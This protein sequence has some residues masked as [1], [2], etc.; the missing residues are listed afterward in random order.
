MGTSG[1]DGAPCG[2]SL[3]GR[4]AETAADER[5]RIVL[6]VVL[7]ET[8]ALLGRPPSAIDPQRPYLDYGYNSLAAVALTEELSSICGLALPLTM[9]FDQPNPDAVARYLLSRMGL[10]AAESATG[11]E[12]PPPPSGSGADGADDIIAVVGVACR[13]PGGVGSPAEL[14]RLVDEGR[15][16]I[17]G[18]P[19]DRGWPLEE[20][21]HPDPDHPGTAYTRSGGFV[22]A[23]TEFD[24]EFFGIS[25]REALAMDPQ[26][27]LL[28]E[29]VWEAFEDA[30]IDPGTL[31]AS[32]TGVFAGVSG[33][34]YSYV[35]R[36]GGTGLQGYWGI[37]TL[38]A[39]ASGRIAY[40]FGFEGPALTVDTACSSSLVATHLAMRSLRHGECS[41]AVV[42]GVT[43]A[44]T[45][46]VYLEFSRQRA[47]S[48]D[49]R[50]R[51]FAETA[52]GTGFS[53]GLG[54]LLLERLSDARRNGHRVHAVL[55]G[56]AM[57]QDGASNG[58]TAPNGPSQE[59]VIRAA[60]ADAGL[61]PDEVD[62]VEA[63]GTAT[64][65]GDPIEAQALLATYG[66]DRTPD[67]PLWLG[68]LKSNIGHTQAAA[69]VGGLIKMIMAMGAE[70]LPATLHADEPTAKVDWSSG[71]VALLTAARP[72]PRAERPRRAGVS[73]FGASGTNAHIIVEEA[74]AEQPAEPGPPSAG[75][76]SAGPR[77]PAA[78]P[79]VW[80]LSGKQQSGLSAQAR[81]LRAWLLAD[82]GL[83][84]VDVGYSLATTRAPLSHR[85]VVV[86]H[87][88]DDLLAG[89][90]RIENRGP[91][92]E[93]AGVSARPGR[94]AFVF[95][96]QGS[97]WAGMAV[98]LLASS[99]VFAERMRE[100][101]EAL[102]PYT[103]W[104][105]LDVLNGAPDAPSLDRVDVVQP[106]L[107]A[108]MV[109][110]AALWRSYGVEPDAVVGHSQ[111]EIAAAC[112]AGALTLDDAARVVS[113]RSKEIATLGRS[114]GMLSIAE[115][116]EDVRARLAMVSGEVSVAAVNGPS[117]VIVSGDSASLDELFEDCVA[118]DVWVRR[119]PVDYASHSPQIEDLRERLHTALAPVTP[120]AGQVAF[121]STVVGK[122]VETTTLDG[123]YWYANLRN[124]V[125]FEQTVRDLADQGHR[126]FVE[127]SPHPV[128]T[129]ALQQSME[130]LGDPDAVVL[131]S[132]KR[133]HGRLEDFLGSLGEAYARGV[134]VDWPAAFAGRPAH[135][136]DLP[137]YAFTRQR[138]WATTGEGAGDPRP[139]GLASAHHPLLAGQVRLAGGLGS[140]FTGRLSLEQL[141]WLTDHTVFGEVFVPGTA[142][143]DLAASAGD[144]LGVPVVEELTLESPLVVR[145]EGIGIQLQVAEPDA[146]GRAAFTLHSEDGADGWTQNASGV[147]AASADTPHT[148]EPSADAPSVEGPSAVWPP[149]GAVAIPIGD[150][151]DRL[152]DRGMEYGGMFRGLRAAW[153]CGDG[154]CAEV[155]LDGGGEDIDPRHLLH[156]ALLDAAFH[157][158]FA[159]RSDEGGSGSARLP[160]A[161]SGV[162][163]RSG[164]HTARELRVRLTPLGADTLR[165]SARDTDGHL[166]VSVDSVLARPVSMAQLAAAR[167]VTADCL[168]GVDWVPATADA[169][170]SPD[171]VAVL[172][173]GEGLETP[174]AY[175]DLRSLLEETDGTPPRWVV[176]PIGLPDATTAPD[177]V[178]TA[179]GSVLSLLREWLA[180]D[181]LQDNR[182]V[183]VTRTAV[184]ALPDDEPT[185]ELAPL[186]GLVRSAQAENP[187]TFRLIDLEAAAGA[188]GLAAALAADEPQV[189]VRDGEL[190]VP[191]TVRT[192]PAASAP[193]FDP[194]TTA[195]I[196]G[197]TGG[198]GA[199]VARHL[200]A[201][202]G[203]RHLL[204]ASRRGPDAEG[205]RALTDELT[206]LGAE[207]R[208]A[209][210]DLA[211]RDA[212]ADLLATVSRDHPLKAVVHAAGVLDDGLI[213][214]MTGGR[215]DRVLRAKADSA[216]HLHELTA[217]HDLTAFVLFS[218]LAG[219]I[220]GPGQGNYAAANTFLDVL[221]HRRR[222]QG[223]PAVSIAWGLWEEASDM[224]GHLS[225][226][227]TARLADSGVIA[228]TAEEGLRLLD[229]TLEAPASLVLAARLD[230]AA[231]RTQA[232]AG[233][234]PAPLRG[235]VRTAPARPAATSAALMEELAGRTGPERA[236]VL[237]R[238]VRT[239]IAAVLQYPGPDAVPPDRAFSDLGFDSLGAV[240][241]RNRLNLA[242]G[243]GLPVTAVFDHP[244]P[245]AVSL[246][247]AGRLFPA[248]DT[249]ADPAVDTAGGG[250]APRD[251]DGA[252]DAA[253]ELDAMDAETLVRLALRGND[254]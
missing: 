29:G 252:P 210:C 191:R 232:A 45:P 139:A 203:V 208:V 154:I 112:V 62:A 215:L 96:G 22:H 25:P 6:D 226:T 162:R 120:R 133:D 150:L 248:G 222:A 247:L 9:L 103:G 192:R 123:D 13:Y 231:L 50:C 177:A 2:E 93:T 148:E 37:G 138:Y 84:P 168:F 201:E 80:V 124:P 125:L 159:D 31:R 169:P 157:A 146:R 115:S 171:T 130:S 92:L 126:V 204:L 14:W 26:Q 147:L 23:A 181:G 110:L 155:R 250:G 100:C 198:L 90:D 11:P 149:E 249:P 136:V 144:R 216:W 21:Y 183:F 87:G 241:L 137:R 132:L 88:R 238:L 236:R 10:S 106:A 56:S 240:Q 40:T 128:L 76:P 253:A 36:S 107:F 235:L 73:S 212:V 166:L 51:S 243:L 43:V 8:A 44:A 42:G 131:G 219:V 20:L 1:T 95:P 175:P 68:S 173:T 180:A 196:T 178:R 214:S 119:I 41:M 64:V 18:F 195:L 179:T 118:E 28:L 34:D 108:M 141:P 186:W 102:E 224:T 239:E 104:R 58:L 184:A 63:H 16:A 105:L 163:I 244:T 91:G 48:P 111:G 213:T 151:Y 12:A 39:V 207:V 199:L 86:G 98:E 142:L 30:G 5:L 67:R 135:R 209:A 190:L 129:A 206:A 230:M 49:G 17:T 193:S 47:L 7:R 211:D 220:G 82:P 205:A 170:V 74:P 57:N 161:W 99:P 72:W 35:A 24:A 4:L 71:A 242:T 89:L 188:D 182:L 227:D 121:H 116:V 97:Q 101:A 46:T 140:V 225:R 66:Q 78:T 55:R 165:M 3:A 54:V 70:T 75:P 53:D 158:A 32:R 223:R 81:R 33:V 77:P 65:L 234:A 15:D 134:E 218:S 85:A 202:H 189:A 60:L 233:V 38:P 221:A 160:F 59:R 145:D 156:P 228:L 52:D 143:V 246:F 187:G 152:A 167:S 94:V 185:L 153:R 237:L 127:V 245:R 254:S 229:A 79:T 174:R 109:S 117:S 69:G 61:S 176:A 83:D 164:E 197:G 200:V 27:R 217:D 194:D 172:G 19:S 114:G 251:D 122:A 113:L